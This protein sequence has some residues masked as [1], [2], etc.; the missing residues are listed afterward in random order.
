MI[1]P[2]K[3]SVCYPTISKIKNI[4]LTHEEG[5]F[6]ERD[7]HKKKV[8]GGVGMVTYHQCNNDA[9]Q[10]IEDFVDPGNPRTRFVLHRC[11][12]HRKN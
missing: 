11:E 2:A 5:T 4:K 7:P 1:D 6:V 3:C 12:I 9:V 10:H 8:V